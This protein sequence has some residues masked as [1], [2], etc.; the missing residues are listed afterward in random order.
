[1]RS[2]EEA[3]FTLV[4]AL[5]ALA[6]VGFV[7]LLLF[8]GM[9]F[10]QRAWQVRATSEADHTQ[11]LAASA[12]IRALLKAAVDPRLEQDFRGAPDRLSLL[13]V[14]QAPGGPA[15]GVQRVTLFLDAG[16][17]RV[18]VVPYDAPEAEAGTVLTLAEGVRGLWFRYLGGKGTWSETWDRSERLPR[19]V[20][21]RFT[22]PAVRHWPAIAVAPGRGPVPE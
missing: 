17:L 14:V 7:S 19:L 11:A 2:R 4:E 22:Q 21:I 5:V 20:E 6:L 1:M 16:A 12:R 18:R 15:A 13:T 8:E 3:G 9:R 10:T